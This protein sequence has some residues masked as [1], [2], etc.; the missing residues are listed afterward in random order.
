[1]QTVQ[2]IRSGNIFADLGVRK[3]L[4][5]GKAI[6]NL[7]VR[8]VFASRIRETNTFQPDFYTYSFSQ[9]G[10]FIVLGFSYG[11]GKG[12]AMEFSGQKRHH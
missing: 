10:R 2:G 8:D 12:E 7:S 11:F 9:R 4:M 6:V 3:K 1:V 5:N